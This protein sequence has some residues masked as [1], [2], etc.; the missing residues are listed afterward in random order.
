MT[1]DGVLRLRI[2]YFIIPGCI[3]GAQ[4]WN[5][6]TRHNVDLCWLHHNPYP[7]TLYNDTALFLTYI[8][9]LVAEGPTR[10]PGYLNFYAIS[11]L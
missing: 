6:A 1:L 4:Q 11:Y 3:H 9:N 10:G 7:S 8:P 2:R 5:S